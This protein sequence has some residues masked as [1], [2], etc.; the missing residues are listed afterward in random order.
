MRVACQR[1]MSGVPYKISR[2]LGILLISVRAIIIIVFTQVNVNA[3]ND[4]QR[5]NK[6]EGGDSGWYHTTVEQLSSEIL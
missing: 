2:N 1:L 6:R 3:I 4:L 5:I